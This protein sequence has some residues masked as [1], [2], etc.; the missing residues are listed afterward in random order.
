MN[1]MT[2]PQAGPGHNSGTVPSPEIIREIL[3]EDHA[4]ILDR[5]EELVRALENVPETIKDEETSGRAT[6][7]VR[8]IAAC[9]KQISEKRTE[10]KKPYLD[11]GRAVDAFFKSVTEE[12]E[13]AKKTVNGRLT[14]YLQEQERIVR[15]KAEEEARAAWQAE[16]AARKE[17][18]AA[19]AAATSEE[20]KAEAERKRQEADAKADE[21]H[22]SATAAVTA[23]AG[24]VHGNY[25]GS[26]SLRTVWKGEITDI[27]AIPLERLRQYLAPDAIDKAIRGFIRDGGRELPG[28]RI[29]EETTAVTR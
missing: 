2:S 10:C 8:Q 7:F 18:E 12:L 4:D 26:S 16:E 11:G 22:R 21:A 28:V 5:A 9:A 6:E 23:S 14:G 3:A 19:A 27:T 1:E 20:D 17:A 13:K 29:F 25:G 15:Q 24:P